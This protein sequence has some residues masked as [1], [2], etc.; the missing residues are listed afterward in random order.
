MWRAFLNALK[1]RFLTPSLK[2][3]ASPAPWKSSLALQLSLNP[4]REA[5]VINAR[6]CITRRLGA[7]FRTVGRRSAHSAYIDSALFL[8]C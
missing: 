7:G 8:E 6:Y 5:H 1:T 2:L 4:A 3:K